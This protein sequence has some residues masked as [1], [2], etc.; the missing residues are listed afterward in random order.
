MELR[1]KRGGVWILFLHSEATDIP[2]ATA[3]T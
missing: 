3:D 2:A 1:R